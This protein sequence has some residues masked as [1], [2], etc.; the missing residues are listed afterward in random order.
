VE[1]GGEKRAGYTRSTKSM[2]RGRSSRKAII[3]S[4]YTYSGVTVV[5]QCCYS[6][7]TV[8]LQWYYSSCSMVLQWSYSTRST[9][10]MSRGRSSRKVDMKPKPDFS[11]L[12]NCGVTVV[13]QWCYFR[14]VKGAPKKKKKN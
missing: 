2:S 9:K 8:L 14:R 6:G 1:G 13:S 7:G 5:V 4:Q 12:P 3:V 11:P 10:S